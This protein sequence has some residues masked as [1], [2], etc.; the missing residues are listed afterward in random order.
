MRTK[1]TLALGL[2]V[3]AV[4]NLGI[5]RKERF[6]EIAEEVFFELAPADSRSLLQGDYMRLNYKIVNDLRG[7]SQKSGN[8]DFPQNGKVKVKLD[9]RRVAS[10]KGIWEGEPLMENERLLRYRK[11]GNWQI[12]VGSESF[13]FEEG[14]GKEYERARYGVLKLGKDSQTILRGLADKDLVLIEPVSGKKSP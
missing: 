14:Q 1:L 6:I 8:E 5:Y 10:L 3:L 2:V 12:K 9:G 13:F 11:I 4:L 7:Y